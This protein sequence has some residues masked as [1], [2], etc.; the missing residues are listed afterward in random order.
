MFH[1]LRMWWYLHGTPFEQIKEL[2]QLLCKSGRRVTYDLK[3]AIDTIE[4]LNRYLEMY[5]PGGSKRFQAE[6]DAFRQRANHWLDVFNPS[7]DGGKNYY[8]KLT[9]EIATQAKEIERLET[10][11]KENNIHFEDPN[12]IPF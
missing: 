5:Q 3:H 6:I 10:L 8:N 12:K 4:T 11:L 7:G 9:G 2:N 1:R